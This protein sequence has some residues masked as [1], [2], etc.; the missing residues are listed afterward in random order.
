M[1]IRDKSGK[2]IIINKIIV[3]GAYPQPLVEIWSSVLYC[4]QGA[5]NVKALGNT[6]PSRI[7]KQL[8]T[9]VCAKTETFQRH[10]YEFT[11]RVPK[12]QTFII[13][14]Q[15]FVTTRQQKKNKQQ[16]AQA[17]LAKAWQQ[18][19]GSTPIRNFHQDP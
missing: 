19:K 8:K 10:L 1:Y 14:R 13:Y 15:D 6:D 17:K 11:K 9:A 16:K 7:N 2:Y 4:L 5:C 3:V 12:L 18:V